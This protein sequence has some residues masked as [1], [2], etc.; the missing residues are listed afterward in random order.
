MVGLI[1][2]VGYMGCDSF[3]SNWQSKVF[4]QYGVYSASM[5]MYSNLFSSGFT[6]LGLLVNLEIL[7]VV[8]YLME[9]PL[10]MTHMLVMSI[11]SAVGQLFIFYTIKHYG[12]LIF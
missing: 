12:P 8:R 3:T 9:N 4:K 6:A 1:L 7:D 2:I 11:C 10:I 5:M